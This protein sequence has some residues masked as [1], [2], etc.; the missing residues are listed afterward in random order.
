MGRRDRED[1]ILLF[2]RKESVWRDYPHIIRTSHHSPS[3]ETVRYVF[4]VGESKNG[5][6]PRSGYGLL[7]ELPNP[8][9]VRS[10]RWRRRLTPQGQLIHTAQMGWERY[11]A[12]AL[13]QSPLVKGPGLSVQAGIAQRAFL[14][15]K[16]H[17]R[18]LGRR[19]TLQWSS[20]PPGSKS[21]IN[22]SYKINYSNAVHNG[23]CIKIHIIIL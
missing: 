15:G 23:N 5:S 9:N 20:P 22:N 7:Y 18:R 14:P 11:C 13:L 6:H 4:P 19:K 8:V 17:V 12:C 10:R 21:S 2:P 16:A 1:M 3:R